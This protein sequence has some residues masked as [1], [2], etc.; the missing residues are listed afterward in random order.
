MRWSPTKRAPCAPGALNNEAI[1]NF[2]RNTLAQALRRN[3]FVCFVLQAGFDAEKGPSLY[4]MDYFGSLA[5]P[6][7]SAQGLC[8]YFLLSLID[9]HWK[10]GLDLEQGLELVKMCIDQLA[11]RY[12]I[13]LQS[14]IV[15]IDL[16]KEVS[17]VKKEVDP[18]APKTVT[19]I[20]RAKQ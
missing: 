5:K 10:E 7:F 20:P 17:L 13:S 6:H 15:K 11:K 8:S 19:G 4:W 1:A 16:T 9:R 12:V 3:P 18:D 2:T 14:F